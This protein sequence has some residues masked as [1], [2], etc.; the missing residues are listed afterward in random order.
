MNS[1]VL[2]GT[3]VKFKIAIDAEDFNIETDNIRL[4]VYIGGAEAKVY[5]KTDLVY[6]EEQGYFLCIETKDFETGQY[7]IVTQL[8]I[9]DP[10]FE[11][12]IR[13][14]IYR[15]NLVFVKPV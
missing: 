2:F 8:D 15:N 5:E 13:T 6:I 9:P 11:D 7:D 1:S 10:A 3:D 14:E 12:N 4:I